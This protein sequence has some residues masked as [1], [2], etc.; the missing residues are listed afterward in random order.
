MPVPRLLGGASLQPGTPS[1][2]RGS[3]LTMCC[4]ESNRDEVPHKYPE[5]G[6][7]VKGFTLPWSLIL[8][9]PISA[10]C[11]DCISGVTHRT[12]PLRAP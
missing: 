9:F 8:T 7:G 1:V 3:H 4:I 6:R 2:G 12:E 5:H 10:G 11:T